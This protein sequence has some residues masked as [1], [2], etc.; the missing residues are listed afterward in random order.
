MSIPTILVCGATGQ[1][2]AAVC[3]RLDAT[4]A[5][6]VGLSR[7]PSTDAR[8]RQADFADTA[9]LPDALKGIEVVFLACSDDPHQDAL[10]INM[11]N[12]C[13]AHGVR[14]VVK[15]SAQ[16]ASLQPPVSFGRLH[17][18][19]EQ[20]LRDSGMAW[21]FLRPV[22]FMQS[23]LFFSDSIKSGKLIAATGKGKVAWVDVR[24]VAQ[25]AAAVLMQPSAHAGKAYTLTG[26]AAHSF[27][28]VT[29]MLRT[30]TGRP[31]KHISPPAWFA[32]LVLPLASGMPRWQSNMAV[33]LMA[34]IS[35]GA[36]QNV[37]ADGAALLTARPRT[38]Q[39]FIAE[40]C[41]AW[42][43]SAV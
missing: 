22:F 38:V 24:D 5:A 17:A 10:E 41:A 43:G 3:Q 34:A 42:G 7:K 31:V 28:E 6:W 30:V 32:K 26:G 2:G 20:A 39:A 18:K 15:L 11:I 29:E 14:H 1:V 9:S 27:A 19:A 23:L 25:V 37:S 35:R 12:A 36:Q 4:G 33:E 40:S 21:T 8:F 16:S 13:R